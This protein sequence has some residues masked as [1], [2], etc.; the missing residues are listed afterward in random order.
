MRIG[1]KQE[2]I[3]REETSRE[4]IDGDHILIKFDDGTEETRL[5]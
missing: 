5:I 1:K 4:E 3:E 2:A